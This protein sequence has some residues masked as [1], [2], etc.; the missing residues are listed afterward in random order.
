[1]LVTDEASQFSTEAA[2]NNALDTISFD[3]FA[4]ET[5]V[6]SIPAKEPVIVGSLPE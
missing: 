5:E 1:M 3:V 2:G 4:F 6:R